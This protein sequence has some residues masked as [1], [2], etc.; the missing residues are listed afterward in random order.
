MRRLLESRKVAVL[1]GVL[2]A[3]LFAICIAAIIPRAG[4]TGQATP[5]PAAPAANESDPANRVDP[6]QTPDSSF[7]YDTS[8]ANL[9][10]ADSS[11]GTTNDPMEKITDSNGLIYMP[12]CRRLSAST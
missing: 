8:I 11:S 4:G 1:V 2:V 10:T 5:E 7:L 3:V 12:D 9:G 6:Q